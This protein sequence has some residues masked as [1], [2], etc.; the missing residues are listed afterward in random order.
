L[1]LV[2]LSA[3]AAPDADG[4]VIDVG[5]SASVEGLEFESTLTIRLYRYFFFI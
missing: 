4:S 5:K 2:P 1:K 3:P